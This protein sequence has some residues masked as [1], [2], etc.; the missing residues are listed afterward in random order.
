MELL[1]SV[2]VGIAALRVLTVAGVTKAMRNFNHP[3]ILESKFL[4]GQ[5]DRY[6]KEIN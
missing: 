6:E 4:C 1:I 5:C 3:Q 2:L